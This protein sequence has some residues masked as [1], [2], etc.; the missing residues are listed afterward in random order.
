MDEGVTPGRGGEE[1]VWGCRG[2]K[3]TVCLVY[4]E[5]KIVC[6]C[7]DGEGSD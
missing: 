6:A 7:K 1:V 4:D 2:D 5:G 3:V